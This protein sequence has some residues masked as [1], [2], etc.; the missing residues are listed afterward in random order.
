MKILVVGGAG[1]I[2][3]HMV[4]MLHH[5]GH[6]IVTID[7]LSSGYR[8]AVLYGQFIEG[9]IANRP[10]LDQLFSKYSFDGVMDFA[11]YIQVGESINKPSMYYENN[12]SNTLTLLSAMMDADIKSFIFSSTAAIFGE[13]KYIP[14]DEKHPQNPINPY[15]HSKLMVE[16]ILRDFE[17]AYGLNS[18]CLRY[19]NAAGADAEGELGERHTPETH[20]IPLIL[21]AAS[22]RRDNISIFGTDYDTPDGTCVRDYIHVEDLCSAHLLAMKSLVNGG[23]SQVYNM[24]NG[25][26]Y[27][28]RDI[29]DTVKIVTGKNFRVVEMPRRDG[30]SERLVAD[31]K[32]LQADLGWKPKYPDLDTI[33]L[34]AWN[35]EQKHNWN[36]IKIKTREV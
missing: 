21:Q 24:G 34:H 13:P 26:G 22:G 12:V 6:T 20:L 9:D 1:Y 33:I 5:A 15:G 35:W 19:F 28:N 29:I 32:R 10:F 17:H 27:S 7:N 4:K 16:Q 25:Q 2:G 30:D 3:S 31:S 14:I 18:I 36:L 23:S 8:N 11:S